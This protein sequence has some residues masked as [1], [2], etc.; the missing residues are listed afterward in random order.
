MFKK[1]IGIN[2]WHPEFAWAC[3]RYAYDKM[4]GILDF[5]ILGSGDNV[6]CDTFINCV[7]MS[8]KIEMKIIWCKN[9]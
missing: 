8:V 7:D 4:E 6:M 1:D 2:Y 5:G 9:R 3:N